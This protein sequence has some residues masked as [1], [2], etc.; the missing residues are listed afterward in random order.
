MKKTK[1]IISFFLVFC[2]LT[3]LLAGCKSEEE[4]NTFDT[5]DT[6]ESLEVTDMSDISNL[7]FYTITNKES[8]MTIE[9]NSLDYDNRELSM[10]PSTQGDKQAFQIY[11]YGENYYI[12]NKTNGKTLMP[13]GL[14][15][16]EGEK[17]VIT[18]VNLSSQSQ[19]WKLEKTENGY[20]KIINSANSLALTED[21]GICQTRSG[22]QDNQLWSI[23]KI[24]APEW[25]L[26]WSDEF[27]GPEIN[28]DNW[29]YEEGYQRND[30]LQSYTKDPKNAFI[31]E[32]YLVIKT[33]K[34]PTESTRPN[35]EGKTT[36]EYSSASL[37]T[38]GKQEWLYGRFEMKAKLPKGQAIW[39]AFWMCGTTDTWPNNGEIDILELWGGESTDG[40]IFCNLHWSE[41]GQVTKWFGEHSITLPNN[42]KFNDKFHT[43]TL[44]WDKNQLRFYMDDLLYA[45][46]YIDTPGMERG[47]RQPHHIWINTA[48]APNK[49]GWGD[50]SINTYPQEYIID[51][52]RVYQHTK[53]QK[54]E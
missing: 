6:S 38:L 43:F 9:A 44:E 36:F 53:T 45:A 48:V 23:K 31:R 47:Y 21:N 4:D 46:K 1:H 14:S 2:L 51:Y 52:I 41:N 19:Q 35:N 16:E 39:P 32:G 7:H 50:A 26:V 8:G 3:A 18:N 12:V 15:S 54:T 29:I 20:F 37:L 28:E 34:E 5:S 25:N 11:K 13:N 33:I 40:K 30:E 49:W 10:K 22:N 24:E 17:I 27:D 42:E